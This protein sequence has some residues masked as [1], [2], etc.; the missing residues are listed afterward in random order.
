MDSSITVTKIRDKKDN[1]VLTTLVPQEDPTD[2]THIEVHKAKEIV[3]IGDC[4][5]IIQ[6]SPEG[7]G[8]QMMTNTDH[9]SIQSSALRVC[10]VISSKRIRESEDMSKTNKKTLT[11]KMV[12]KSQTY[13]SIPS[14]DFEKR[15]VVVTPRERDIKLHLSSMNISKSR[16]NSVEMGLYRPVLEG[17]RLT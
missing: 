6:D 9:D 10:E 5:N 4:I 3:M 13:N 2:R 8:I 1:G 7:G 15:A 17:K 12:A 14:E 16:T 11:P